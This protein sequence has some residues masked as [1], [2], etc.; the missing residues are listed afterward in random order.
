MARIYYQNTVLPAGT[1]RLSDVVPMPQALL[2]NWFKSD[3]QQFKVPGVVYL[4]T[5]NWSCVYQKM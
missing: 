2:G 1:F 4:Y 5:D 3:V